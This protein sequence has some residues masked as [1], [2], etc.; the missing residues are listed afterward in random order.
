MRIHYSDTINFISK[1]SLP[2]ILN[3]GKI[4]LSYHWSKIVGRAQIKGLPISISFEP[5]TACNLRCPECPSGLRSFSR[6]TGNLKEDFFRETIDQIAP[7]LLFLLFYFQGE[8]FINPQFLE[9]VKYASDKNIYTMTSTN[10]HFLTDS[11]ARKTV[12]SGLDRL[13]VSIDGLTQETY[14]TYRKE[15]QLQ[16]VIE[17]V[18]NILKWKEKLRSKTPHV[19]LQFLVVGPNEHE[20][21]ALFALAKKLG[22]KDVKLKSAQVYDFQHG[23]PLIPEN[24]IYSRYQKKADGTYEVKHSIGNQCWKMWHS[25]VLTWDGRIVPCCFD[26]DAQHQLGNLHNSS[27]KEIWTSD[28]YQQFRNK[29]LYNRKEIDICSNCTEGAK[30]WV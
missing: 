16:K 2:R 8:P 22:V 21:P 4:L 5:T 6:P 10:G 29:I 3:A 19:I 11:V 27:F 13:I 24:K 7:K 25:C 17:G 28:I 9:M 20:I 18:K 26:K 15:G 30:V 12:E 1:L 14:A 23:N